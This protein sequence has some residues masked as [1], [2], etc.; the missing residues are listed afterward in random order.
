MLWNYWEASLAWCQHYV[1][2]LF[3]LAGLLISGIDDFAFDVIFL[4]RAL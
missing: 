3:A 4:A 2:L 1:N